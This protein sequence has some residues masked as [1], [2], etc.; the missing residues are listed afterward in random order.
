MFQAWVFIVIIMEAA[1]GTHY[2][3][4]ASIV[5]SLCFGRFYIPAEKENRIHKS[6]KGSLTVIKKTCFHLLGLLCSSGAYSTDKWNNADVQQDI[7]RFISGL[8]PDILTIWFCSAVLKLG[9]FQCRMLKKTRVRFQNGPLLYILFYIFL[10]LS[11]YIHGVFVGDLWVFLEG[12]GIWLRR[13]P[14]KAGFCY[15][16]LL[17]HSIKVPKCGFGVYLV[18]LFWF[19]VLVCLVFFL[20]FNN[21]IYPY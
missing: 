16:V 19:L 11:I 15:L 5:L 3:P 20:S 10:C 21:V 14:T 8:S 18:V 6:F 12:A 1:Q 9:L 4:L 13:N 7:K 17:N 2:K